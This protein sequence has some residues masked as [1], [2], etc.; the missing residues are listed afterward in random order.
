MTQV[1]LENLQLPVG[2]FVMGSLS[3]KGDKDYD[4]HPIPEEKQRYFFGVAVPKTE[5]AFNDLWGAIYGMA[6]NGYASNPMVLQEI[7][8]GLGTKDFSWKISDGD[9]PSYDRQT[10]QVRD[11]P[12]Y[13]KGCWIFKFSTMF[14][15]DACAYENGQNVQIDR[16]RDI[17]RGD[18]VDLVFSADVNERTGDQAGIYLNPVAIRRVGFG[19][20]IS[21]SVSAVNAFANAPAPAMPAG[22]S[23]TPTAPAMVAPGNAPAPAPAAAPPAPTAA[24]APAPAPTAAPQYAPPAPGTAV[25]PAPAATPAGTTASP[26]SPPVPGVAPHPGILNP[27]VPGQ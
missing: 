13:L 19:E 8:K 25:A 1:K 21:G 14:E 17:K 16:V 6:Y 24:P 9:V 20:A 15:I 22:A 27:P 11:I 7:Q 2:R 3:E 23:A 12:E 4:G 10:G 18:Y 26:S 5:A